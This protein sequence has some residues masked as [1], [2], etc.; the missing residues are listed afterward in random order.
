MGDLA[1]VAVSIGPGS[2]TGLRI[3]VAAAKGLA[4]SL[5][6]PLYGMPS[7]EVLAGNASPGT[8]AVCAVID[9]RR[10]ELFG[11]LFRFAGGKA[12]KAWGERILTPEDLVSSLPGDAVIFGRLPEPFRKSLEKGGKP[13]SCAP[14]H[15]SYPR[16]AVVA[17]TGEGMLSLGRASETD[18]LTPRYLRPSDAE[19]NRRKKREKTL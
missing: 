18:T 13:F 12:R 3:G 7:L 8:R 17:R 5:G 10:G 15:L 9:A 4:F 2:F 16:A 14:P 11:A 6:L 1:A 19:A